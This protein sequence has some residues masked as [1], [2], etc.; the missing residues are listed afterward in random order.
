MKI[1]GIELGRGLR[2]LLWV[3]TVLFVVLVIAGKIL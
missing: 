1:V 2:L 3:W